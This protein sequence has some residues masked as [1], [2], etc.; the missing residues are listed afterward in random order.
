MQTR[1]LIENGT[2]FH[3][4]VST[5]RDLCHINV[6]ER[7]R[8]RRRTSENALKVSSELVKTFAKCRKLHFLVA[9]YGSIADSDV[10]E[11]CGA[12][13]CWRVE[14]SIRMGNFFQYRQT[15]KYLCS[16]EVINSR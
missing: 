11:I 9:T 15:G 16:L 7:H 2:V 8:G 12:L 10:R 6:S 3:P 1:D 14:A 5:N 13:P 4:I